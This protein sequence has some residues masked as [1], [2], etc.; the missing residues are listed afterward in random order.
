MRLA[1]LLAVTLAITQPY[2]RPRQ[3][4][5]P[6]RPQSQLP[7][8]PQLELRP[9]Q[10]PINLP[11]SQQLG[12]IS[13]LDRDPKSNT[14]WL[15]QRGPHAPPILAID[16]GTNRIL[17]AF[18]GGS[19]TTPHAIRV[20]P[21]GTVWT[22]DAGTSQI[23]HWTS[24]G[25]KLLT[26]NLAPPSPTPQS[27]AGATDIAFAPN[28]NLLISDGY[29][30]ARILEYTPA[31]KLLRQWGTPGNGPGQFNLPHALLFD[32]ETGTLY[33]ADRENARIQKFTS[34]GR[35]LTEFDHL[36]RIYD[37]A[38]GPR[39]TL[40]ATTS[41]L[42]KPPGSPGQILQLD[43]TTGKVLGYLPVPKQ[44]AL[45]TLT[46]D[47]HGQPLTDIGNTILYFR[48]PVTSSSA[49]L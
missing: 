36:G 2:G 15:L 14:L 46:T 28:G 44:P 27:F 33:V 20:A 42:A 29:Q 41:P 17:H 16:L 13:W 25:Q 19:F 49:R 38:L 37:L 4:Q 6:N 48:A 5:T 1:R 8:A 39:S 11:A 43:R 18:G 22:V 12:M 24:Q 34:N 30:N 3:S 31:G 23:L 40:W 7:T 47:S 10:L 9:S 26:L 45:H 35:F 32:N 21:D